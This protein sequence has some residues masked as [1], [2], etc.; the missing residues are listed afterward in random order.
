MLFPWYSVGLPGAV[1][2]AQAGIQYSR[3]EQSRREDASFSGY[4]YWIACLRGR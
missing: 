3:S 4:D 1:M 2:P